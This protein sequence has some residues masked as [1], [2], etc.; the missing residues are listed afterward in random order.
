MSED[1]KRI[2][3]EMH[4]PARRNYPRPKLD[5]KGLNETWQADF[6]VMEDYWRVSKGYKYLL[7]IIDNYS[8]FAWAVPLKRKTG[9]AVA[10]AFKCI[11]TKSVNLR[12]YMQIK[13]R[14]STTR[15]T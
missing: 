2:V 12:I 14:S 4:K 5:I 7:T 6:V 9:A 11:L 8:K 15:R 3:E 1:K 10:T 13:A